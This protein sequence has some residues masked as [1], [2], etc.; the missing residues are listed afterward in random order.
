V[1]IFATDIDKEAVDRARQGLYMP[2]IATDVSPERL[3]RFFAKD[4]H[5]YRVSKTIREMVVFAPQNLIMD[6]PFT[7]LD[8]LC[9]RNLLIYFNAELQK[10]LLP[11][12]HYTLNAGGILFLGSSESIGG[13]QDLFGTVDHKWKIFRRKESPIAATAGLVDFPSAL[14]PHEQGKSRH[15]PK[16]ATDAGASLPDL[17]RQLLLERFV[18][19][20]VLVNESGDILYI[21]GRT[22]RYLEPATGEATMNIFTMAREGLRLEVGALVRKA[23]LQRRE[24][25]R[26]GLRVQVN[27]GYQIVK[28]LVRPLSG[29]SITRGMVLISFEDREP[30]KR[31]SRGKKESGKPSNETEDLAKE[32]KYTKEQLQNTVEE[33]ET[34]HEELKSANEELQSTNEEL[35]S[36]NE[37][38][39]TSKEE[40]QSLNEELVTVNSELQQ[41]IEDVS[42]S[43]NDMKNLLNSTDIATVFVDNNLSIK[44]FTP[45]AASVINVI[46]SDVGR[47]ISDI[48][49]NLKHDGLVDDLKEVLR[50]LAY[51]EMQ[52]ET[53]QGDWYLLRIMPYRTIENVIGGGVLTFTNINAV[54]SLEASLRSSESRLHRLFDGMAVMFVAFD[55]QHRTVAWNHECERVTGYRAEDMIGKPDAF[56]LLSRS[57]KPGADRD[58][59]SLGGARVE[60]R[61]ISC[62]D[63]SVRYAAWLPMAL[64]GWAQCWVGIDV[65]ER[66]EAME[67]LAGL[68]DSSSVALGFSTLEGKFLEVNRVFMDLTGYTKG[69]L[70]R[71]SY[72]IL[73]SPEYRGRHAEIVEQIVKTG[74]PGTFEKEY[75]RKDGTRVGVSATIFLVHGLEGK[76]IGLGSIVKQRGEE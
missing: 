66:R 9:C 36:T 62:K 65:T 11:L 55:E 49:T 57:P 58:G 8:L 61:S 42:Q 35:Q 46:P 70:L 51:K 74:Q 13:F 31:L 5:G 45:Q 18:P 54:K 73:L 72:H 20:S 4:D 21:Q 37:E 19:P 17:S 34:S 1:Q 59:G 24:V 41:K 6:P 64:S 71:Q 75:V 53:K 16:S 60:E 14:L 76:P 7:K 2:T 43:N 3:H 67:R 15:Q 50:T 27:G 52:I 39:T 33:M 44:R 30:A 25:E 69:E 38:L 23:L 47:P 40:L 22:G 63:G 32:L 56:Q 48:A 29:R 28:I 26:D 10:K 12:F 68:F